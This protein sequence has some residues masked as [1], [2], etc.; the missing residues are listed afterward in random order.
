MTISDN[1]VGFDPATTDFGVGL[2]NSKKR[3][4]GLSGAE[5]TIDSAPGK[6]T[7]VGIKIDVN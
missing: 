2:N 4:E 6:G 3:F 7:R 5:M 1:G